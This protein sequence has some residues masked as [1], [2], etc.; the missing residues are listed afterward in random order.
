MVCAVAVCVCISHVGLGWQAGGRRA[1]VSKVYEAV[2]MWVNKPCPRRT[3]DD[4]ALRGS[5]RVLPAK[6]NAGRAAS[7]SIVVPE[8]VGYEDGRM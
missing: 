5:I 3:Y 8:V 7:C 6:R 1:A 2:V 4:S